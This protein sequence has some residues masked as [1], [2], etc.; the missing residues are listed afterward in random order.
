MRT[1]EAWSV[2]VSIG[3]TTQ[4][5]FLGASEEEAL[6]K[7]S[8]A[9][10]QAET[11]GR[12]WTIKQITQRFFIGLLI[13]RSFDHLVDIFSYE[14]MCGPHNAIKY[15]HRYLH[16][17]DSCGRR[18]FWNYGPKECE[19]NYDLCEDLPQNVF[20]DLTAFLLKCRKTPPGLL[21]RIEDPGL[22]L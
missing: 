14:R 18:S 6:T 2:R 11:D 10:K 17:T 1:N 22:G 20:D 12:A 21:Q 15:N 5:S 7:A 8:E 4:L 16:W 3:K 13:D 9:I 19:G